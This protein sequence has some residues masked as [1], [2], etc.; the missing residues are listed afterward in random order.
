MTLEAKGDDTI[1]LGLH[2]VVYPFVTSMIGFFMY[3]K[4]A[5][6]FHQ[7]IECGITNYK[8]LTMLMALAHLNRRSYAYYF[9]I[10]RSMFISA[11][12]KKDFA[13]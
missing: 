10:W 1:A 13:A 12:H 8:L 5:G 4:M 6:A 9:Y 2:F 3:E 7:G 11:P